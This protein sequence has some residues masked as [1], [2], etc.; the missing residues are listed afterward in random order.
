ML[1]LLANND[2]SRPIYFTGGAYADEEY[3]WLK[4]YL[5]ADGMSYKLVPIK[6]SSEKSNM[7]DLGRID[8]KVMYANVKKIDWRNSS[9]PDVYIDVETRKN[10]ISF[11]SMLNRLAEKLIEEKDFSKA[12]EILDLS[13]DNMPVKAYK[14]YSLALGL[15]ENYYQ[16]EKPKK[17]QK[18]ADE[19]LEVFQDNLRYYASLKGDERT[20]YYDDAETDMLMYGS[21]IDS[22]SKGDKQYAE[23]IIDYAMQ[24]IPFDVY[25]KEGLCLTAIEGYYEIGKPKKAQALSLQLVA[26][27]NKELS[28]FSQSIA[29]QNN[30]SA[31]FNSI[32]PSV[33]FYQYVM[34]ESEK[35]DTIFYK[36]LRK[37]Y[38]EAF[39]MLEKAMD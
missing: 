20:Y 3:I 38:D 36:E 24:N 7:L 9:S 18:V 31:S 32:K 29:N 34:N 33:E 27:Y 19:L 14:H 37:G 6:T 25:A 1:D 2:W 21:I 15:I 39:T 11:R 23:K 5:Q 4:D 30:L 13:V 16:L 10:S 12:E 17:A 28:D 26:S 22:A 8:T 35:V